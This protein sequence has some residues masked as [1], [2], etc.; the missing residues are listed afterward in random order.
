MEAAMRRTIRSSSEIDLVFRAGNKGATD[1]VIVMCGATPQER[2]PEGR[3]AFIA[4][5]K[6]GGAVVR[7]RAKR[8]LRAAVARAGGPWPTA[9]VLVIARPSLLGARAP[10]VDIALTSALSKARVPRG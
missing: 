6:L 2:G 8:I 10:D 5:K 1:L 3:V 4:G 9:D 7:N